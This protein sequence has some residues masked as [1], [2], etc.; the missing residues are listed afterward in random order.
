MATLTTSNSYIDMD[1][2]A[3]EYSF[4]YFNVVNATFVGIDKKISTPQLSKVTK[5][6]IKQTIGKGVRAG[7]GL[8][9]FLQGSLR[10]GLYET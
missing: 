4:Q 6:G 8:G 10:I 7:Y 9:K 2:N 3:I 5:L 1:E